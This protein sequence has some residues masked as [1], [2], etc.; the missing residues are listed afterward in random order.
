MLACACVGMTSWAVSVSLSGVY[1]WRTPWKRRYPRE[2]QRCAS[3]MHLP[4]SCFMIFFNSGSVSRSSLMFLLPLAGKSIFTV[5]TCS[6]MTG[7]GCGGLD[8]VSVITF[9]Y[10]GVYCT[11]RL[12]G[13]SCNAHLASRPLGD[14]RDI[15]QRNCW[16]SV[17]AITDCFSWINL[18]KV[19]GAL[20]SF[21]PVFW[22]D[23]YLPIARF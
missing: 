9:A 16:W 21:V 14:F 12:Y 13:C 22:R 8:K 11:L 18:W 5:S 15:S 10:P 20:R 19:A 23:R 6:F 4:F 3:S 7:S 1:R 17:I 2:S